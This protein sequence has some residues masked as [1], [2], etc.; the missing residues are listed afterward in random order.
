MYHRASSRAQLDHHMSLMMTTILIIRLLNDFSF[1]NWGSSSV[2]FQL[3]G[4]WLISGLQIP[5][6][7]GRRHHDFYAKKGTIRPPKSKLSRHPF[8]SAIFFF[9]KKKEA[10]FFLWPF[11]NFLSCCCIDA[12]WT[13]LEEQFAQEHGKK[14][15]GKALLILL[16]YFARENTQTLINTGKMH[17]IGVSSR[18]Q[19]LQTQQSK[20][21]QLENLKIFESDS[22]RAGGQ[23]VISRALN[24]AC[25][26]SQL[27]FSD[28]NPVSWPGD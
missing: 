10:E 24:W 7:W 12:F 11:N 20:S 16:A 22:A 1:S 14:K 27:A 6:N 4:Y 23:S 25:N 5:H 19:Q 8:Q 28:W 2:Q 9:G 26:F 13:L 17:R 18:M 3:R 15:W 21:M